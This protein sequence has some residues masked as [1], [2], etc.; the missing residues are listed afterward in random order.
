MSRRHATPVPA[1]F[2]EGGIKVSCEWCAGSG[3]RRLND[4]ESRTLAAAQWAIDESATGWATTGA[5]AEKLG[6]RV[7]R[8]ALLYRLAHLEKLGLLESRRARAADNRSERRGYGNE[9]EWRRHPAS[10][11]E[12]S[13]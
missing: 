10:L 6:R 3:R 11:P 2:V 13:R 1:G 8:S 7:G 12:A 5:V 4:K 9:K